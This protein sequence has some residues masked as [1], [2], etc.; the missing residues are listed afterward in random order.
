MGANCCDSSAA[1]HL[2]TP[3][4]AGITGGHQRRDDF[5]RVN[6]NIAKES[7]KVEYFGECYGRVDP[8]RQMLEHKGA[9]YQFIG[10]TAEGWANLKKSGGNTGEFGGLPIVHFGGEA[11]QQTSALLRSLGQVHG[12]Y[13]ASNWKQAVFIDM[14]VETHSDLFNATMKA[15][16]FTPGDQKAAAMR[17]VKDGICTKFF[18]ICE[19]RLA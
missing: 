19:K 14:I 5:A 9:D 13:D 12:Y 6:A 11:R 7:Y 15:A 17:A 3:A 18:N 1:E 10:H 16:L 4:P 2:D 8:I